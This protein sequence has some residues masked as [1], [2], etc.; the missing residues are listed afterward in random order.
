MYDGSFA[1]FCSTFAK[2]IVT[3]E[4]SGDESNEANEMMAATGSMS[5]KKVFL[6]QR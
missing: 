5:K 3:L 1:K 4:V 2:D 6:T